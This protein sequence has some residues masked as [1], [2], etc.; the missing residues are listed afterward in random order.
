MLGINCKYNG[1]NNYNKKI[2]KMVKDG[3]AILQPKS[4]SCGVGKIYSRNF[5]NRLINWNGVLAQLLKENVIGSRNEL[6]IIVNRER[7]K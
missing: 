3:K 4:T 2:F 6:E 5:D 7:M 1:G